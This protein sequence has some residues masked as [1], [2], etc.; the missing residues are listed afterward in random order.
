MATPLRFGLFSLALTCFAVARVAA[1]EPADLFPAST[2]AYAEVGNP[3]AT[4]DMLAAFLKGTILEDP[5]KHAHDRRDKLQPGQPLVGHQLAGDLSLLLAPETLA[6]FIKIKSVSAGFTGFDSKTGRPRFALAIQLGESQLTGFL[7]RKYLLTADNVRRV[8]KIDDVTIYQNRGLSGVVLDENQKPDP[9]TDPVPATGEFEPTYLYT[10]GLFVIGTGPK[11]V[12]DVLRRFNGKEKSPSFAVNPALADFR[13]KAGIA[14]WADP[15]AFGKQFVT[16]K[17]V[18]PADWMKSLPAAFVQFVVQPKHFTELTGAFTL[19]PDGWNLK[20]EAK[21][22][23]LQG[24]PL[25]SLLLG[26]ASAE[27]STIGWGELALALPPEKDRAKG[28]VAAAD[29]FAVASG[30]AGILPSERIAVAEKA[31]VKFTAELLPKIERVGV[32]MAEFSHG[33]ENAVS[34]PVVT[35]GFGNDADA[36]AW[37]AAAGELSKLISGADKAPEPASET[38]QKH[39]VFGLV[40][41]G[42]PVHYLQLGNRIFIARHR[43]DVVRATEAKPAVAED[44][45]LAGRVRFAKIWKAL[46]PP[47]EVVPSPSLPSSEVGSEPIVDPLLEIEKRWQASLLAMPDVKLK[48][49]VNQG[50]LSVELRQSEMKKAFAEWLKSGWEKWEIDTGDLQQLKGL[51][52]EDA[53]AIKK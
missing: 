27:R 5:S 45:A 35:L 41:D 17:K 40:H 8:G 42:M 29:A 22:M 33:K 25:A 39:K 47:S 44:A 12:L 36:A 52:I 23:D 43:D 10:P 30:H 13:K 26:K 1:V 38:I 53:P 18:N 9:D 48:A 20:L 2:V 24:S 15:V 4:V 3:S 7:V 49:K 34:L 11:S 51:H 28:I 50:M 21:A 19:Q 16:A 37:I 46:L 6:D 14:F 31:G 32:V